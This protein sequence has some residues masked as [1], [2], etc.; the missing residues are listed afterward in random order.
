[1]RSP[2]AEAALRAMFSADLSYLDAVYERIGALW[3]DFGGYL[4]DGLGV[5]DDMRET[6][7]RRYLA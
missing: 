7:R 3:G 6:I 2:E 1:M 5:T 4:R